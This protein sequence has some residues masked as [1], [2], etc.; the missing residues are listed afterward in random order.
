MGDLRLRII[1]ADDN[2][3]M[4]ESLRRSLLQ[5]GHDV[6]VV[7]GGGPLVG[8][9]LRESPDVVLSDV[10]MP[11]LDG[12]AATQQIRRWSAVPV[13]LLSNTW[14]GD[15]V[16]RALAAGATKCLTK[17]VRALDLVSV[18]DSLREETSQSRQSGG[19]LVRWFLEGITEYAVFSL[20][21]DGRVASWNRGAECLFGYRAAEVV[22][23]PWALLFAPED[24]R[25]GVCDK[26]LTAA[27][28]GRRERACWF[29]KK[30]GVRVKTTVIL[31]VLRDPE[32][33]VCGYGAI[34][35]AGI[36]CSEAAETP[37]PGLAV[38]TWW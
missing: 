7:A 12:I 4:R 31:A 10:Q 23:R 33:K 15:D 37:C 36:P 9:C 6:T 8:A 32:G 35:R 30:D 3:M 22:S 17:P 2:E 21:P 29:T 27:R 18:L 16:V 1:V 28:D 20:E 38:E 11:D 25:A 24:A 34:A 13:I 5:L 26:V 19:I 14:D